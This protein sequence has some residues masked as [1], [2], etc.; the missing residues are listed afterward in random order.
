ML[1]SAVSLRSLRQELLERTDLQGDAFCHALSPA[2]TAGWPACS[3]QPPTATPRARAWWPWAAT[4]GAS[5][6]PTAISTW[7]SSTTPA[8]TSAWSPTP[9]GTRCGTRASA[10]TTRCVARPRSWPWRPRTS[11]PNSA[12]STADVVAGDADRWPPCW[13]GPSTCGGPEP[14]RW[15]PV[16]AAQVEERHRA[17]GDVAFLLEPDLKEAHG[18]LRDFHA[19]PAAGRAVPALAEQVDLAVAVGPAGRAH[20]RPR[21][22]APDHRPRHRPASAPG[23]GPGGRGPRLRRRRRPHGGR[24]PRRDGPSPG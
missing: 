3:N 2:P 23:A 18:G 21:R 8:R 4:A 13:P 10:S 19:V 9:S 17:H 1:P 20:R 14:A 5:C 15:L 22:A 7:C 16:L 11:G 24:S 6:A 12:C